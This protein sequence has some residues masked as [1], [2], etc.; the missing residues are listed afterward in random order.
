MFYF[1]N[2]VQ[3]GDE[4]TLCPG[5]VQGCG[6]CPALVL[7]GRMGYPDQVTKSFSQ[8]TRETVTSTYLEIDGSNLKCTL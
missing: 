2:I 1:V 7:L 3:K 8:S 4:G 5:P 6:V